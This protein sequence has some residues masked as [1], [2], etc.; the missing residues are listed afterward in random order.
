MWNVRI[1]SCVPG[2][3]I[4]WAAM[5]A[6][7]LADVDHVAARQVA[8][9]AHRA[10]AALGLAGQHRAD[11]HLV[12]ARSIFDRLATSSSISS[13][14]ATITSSV[15]GSTMSSSATRP[16]IRS[17]RRSMIS[18]A[19]DRA[20]DLDAVERAAVVLD[21]DA[22]CATST[23][24]RV[25]Y[26]EFAV[27]SAVSA[28][29]L[30]GAVGRDEVLEHRQA[31]AEVRRDRRL[32]DLARTAWPSGRACRPAAGSACSPRAPESAIMKIGLKLGYLRSCRV[33]LT[34]SVNL[35]SSLR[36]PAPS[37]GP[38]VDD[39]VVPLAVGDQALGVL[40]SI[41]STSF[42]AASRTSPSCWPE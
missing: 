42:C 27:L 6:D 2:S 23:S 37:P 34:V 19:L 36:R 39:L 16:R 32:D 17:P 7:R 20:A 1:V 35:R 10:D 31:L 13:L 40:L 25:R 11:L 18:P 38:D 8:A 5:I 26:P 14:A 28:E 4:D 30:A 21:D 41:S 9:V 24:R 12:D 3:P 22:S 33:V 29:T 15:N